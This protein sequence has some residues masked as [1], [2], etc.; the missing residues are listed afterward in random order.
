MLGCMG[1]GTRIR[2]GLVVAAFPAIFR[3]DAHR[4]DLVRL[5]TDYGGWWVPESLLGPSSICYCGGVGTDISFDLGLIERFGSR[6]WGIDPT[7]R[8]GEWIAKQRLD[9]RFTFVPV[10]LSGAAGELRFYAPQDPDHV[11]HSSKNLQGTTTYFTARVQTLAGMM[12]ELGHDHLDLVKLDIEGAEHDTIERMLA[13]G[14]HPTVVCVEYDQPEPLSW[15]R[16][17]TA[18]LRAAGY[19]LVKLETLNLTFVRS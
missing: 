7:P 1:L 5:G 8:S 12:T 17:T 3:A 10:G 4:D 2:K 15:A 9:P 6:V 16:R 13:D 14:I 19:E 11:S 18:A